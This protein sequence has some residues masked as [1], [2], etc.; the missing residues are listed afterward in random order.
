MTIDEV[1]DTMDELLDKAAAV[2]FS[3]KKCIVDSEQMRDMINELRLNLP[4]EIKQARHIT[5]DR[6]EIIRQANSE[7][8]AIIKR[9]EDR[10]KSIASNDEIV[11]LAKIQANEILTGAQRG[12]K[13]AKSAVDTYVDAVL[14]KSE[15][16]LRLNLEDIRKKRSE[17][18]T[19][20]MGRKPENK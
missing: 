11:R 14:I 18:K 3:V 19:I 4:T 8:E 9:A 5:Q 13:E 15:E 6:V 17:M 10:A 20:P 16:T 7:A 12:M 2:P 1:L